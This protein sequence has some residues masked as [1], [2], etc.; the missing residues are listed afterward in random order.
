MHFAEHAQKG[1]ECGRR[2]FLTDVLLGLV[3]AALRRGR[4]EHPAPSSSDVLRL[5]GTG[6]YYVDEWGTELS[7]PEEG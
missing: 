1:R 3:G 2:C 6:P 5:T 4:R 7:Q